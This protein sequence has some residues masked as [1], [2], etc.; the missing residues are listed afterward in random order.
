MTPGRNGRHQPQTEDDPEVDPE[1]T[2]NTREYWHR[3]DVITEKHGQPASRG[4]TID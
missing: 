1:R 3:S 2:A 4:V